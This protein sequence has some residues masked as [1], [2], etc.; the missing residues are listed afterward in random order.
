MVYLEDGA[1]SR[2][3]VIQGEIQVVDEGTPLNKTTARL[4]FM[5]EYTTTKN[6]LSEATRLLQSGHST[7]RHDI[8]TGLAELKEGIRQMSDAQKWFEQFTC[9]LS[10]D[11]ESSYKKLLSKLHYERRKLS[12]ELEEQ[13][14]KYQ[15]LRDRMTSRSQKTAELEHQPRSGRRR[16]D[17]IDSQ[18]ENDND[19]P[20]SQT[21]QKA[22][23]RDVMKRNWRRI[24]MVLAGVGLTTAGSVTGIFPLAGAGLG[25][26]LHGA[27]QLKLSRKNK[28]QLEGPYDNHNGSS[29]LNSST[30]TLNGA[31]MSN[32]FWGNNNN[33]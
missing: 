19:M 30:A 5:A 21:M 22:R 11:K 8:D 9:L 29:A 23:K 18:S 20:P 28:P 2:H 1:V 27:S 25:I 15:Q 33:N 14:R 26:T 4:K 6:K 32:L 24:I 10:S 16:R 17:E 13:K 31:Q 3:L 7:S 12:D